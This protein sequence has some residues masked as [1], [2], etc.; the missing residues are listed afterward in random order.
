MSE[1]FY[2]AI[3]GKGQIETSKDLDI[4]IGLQYNI[5]SV[6]PFSHLQEGKF[7]SFQRHNAYSL[8]ND[9]KISLFF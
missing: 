8:V 1:R 7:V 3:Y 9:L 4:A 2:A 6:D 5:F